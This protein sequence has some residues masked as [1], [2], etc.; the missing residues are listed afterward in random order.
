MGSEMCIRDSN[1]I[2]LFEF[3]DANN[4]TLFCAQPT[5]SPILM[6]YFPIKVNVV[7]GVGIQRCAPR[8]SSKA[9]P[10]LANKEAM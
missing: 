8:S 10:L 1:T 5:L 7:R 2:L 4:I 6:R 9:N 3:M